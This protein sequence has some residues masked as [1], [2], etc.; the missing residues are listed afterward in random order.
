[1]IES[2]VYADEQVFRR[3]LD[4]GDRYEERPCFRDEKASGLEREADRPPVRTRECPRSRGEFSSE[5]SEI[6]LVFRRPVRNAEAASEIDMSY[7]REIEGVSKSFCIACARI[8]TDKTLEPICWARPVSRSPY[9]F[10]SFRA[11]G[12]SARD[13]PNLLSGPPVITCAWCP[14]PMPW[15]EPE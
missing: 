3:P 7:L 12:I 14:A 11:A 5:P 4:V 10:A 9:F 1:M 13:M 2:G 8:S 15:I 6:E